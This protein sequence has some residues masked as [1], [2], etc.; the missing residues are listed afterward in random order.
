MNQ[1]AG[2][3]VE[4]RG[5]DIGRDLLD[6]PAKLV[7]DI[8]NRDFIGQRAHDQLL[9]RPQLLGL[10]D[11]GQQGEH[12]LDP[13]A[14]VAERLDVGRDPDL[15]A[16]L[17]VGEDFLL[18]A[19]FLADPA[20]QPCQRPAVGMATDKQLDRLPPLRFLDRVPEHSGKRGVDIDDPQIVVGDDNR[21][22]GPV[23]DQCEQRQPFSSFD[24][25]GDVPN[26]CDGAALTADLDMR[27]RQR[28]TDPAAVLAL[29]RD[30]GAASLDGVVAVHLT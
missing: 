28:G 5:N 18:A 23:G 30:L 4:Q 1:S 14:P 7:G 15:V 3:D 13:P 21:A 16:V 24:L 10:G 27:K 2:V 8:R 12:V 29:D 11:I 19:T 26:E 9:Q 6:T 22:V 25:G 20:S 17:V